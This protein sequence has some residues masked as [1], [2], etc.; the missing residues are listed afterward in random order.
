MKLKQN[1]TR[2]PRFLIAASAIGFLLFLMMQI[3]IPQLQSQQAVEPNLRLLSKSEAEARATSFI[4]QQWSGDIR[5]APHSDTSVVYTT[6]KMFS[7]YVNKEG[8]L[9]QYKRWDK[10]APMDTYR[11]LLP[12]LAGEQAGTLRVDIHLTTGSVVG[13]GFVSDDTLTST[14]T[15]RTQQSL[16]DSSP[17]TAT[18]QT[19]QAKLAEEAAYSL[20]WKKQ[21][22]VL[23]RELPNHTYLFHVPTAK[24]GQSKLH[25]EVEVADRAVIRAE[26]V[27][28]VPDA[29]EQL[30]Q[31]QTDTAQNVY[32]Y[33][34]LWVSFALSALAILMCIRYRNTVR[35]GSNTMIALTLVSGGISLLHIWNVLPSQIALELEV[36][37]AKL[38]LTFI[39]LIQYG[40]TL[41]QG[42]GVYFALVAGR[43]LWKDTTY[44]DLMP[45]WRNAHF[46]HHLVRSLWLGLLF[47]GLLLGVQT[48]IFFCLERGFDTWTAN[49][50]QQSPLNMTYM[51]FFPLLAWVAAISEEVV[52]RLFGVGLFLR[53]LR[54]PWLAGMI[55]TLIWAFGHV[56]YPVYPFYS[57]PLELLIIGFCFLFIMVKHGFWTALFAHL[58]IDT[59]LMSQYFLWSGSLGSVFVGITYLLLPIVIVYV[60]R[61]YHSRPFAKFTG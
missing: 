6:N 41:I 38:N 61:A 8:V 1:R 39:S 22:F 3:I 10:Q 4:Q 25:I 7:G 5:V 54:N 24:V 42:I 58:M 47:A 36:P 50:A 32:R 11:V 15:K 17:S 13:F 30:I 27:W 18:H 28:V 52:Y 21:S 14:S 43:Q 59:I 45:T 51:A 33:G 57:R 35:F 56:L 29:Y 16:P 48:I 23:D 31:K 19:Q 34:Y 26:P 49:D 37:A 44:G 40:I 53:W 20:G 55:P 60:I 2:L 46:G 9:E 12:V